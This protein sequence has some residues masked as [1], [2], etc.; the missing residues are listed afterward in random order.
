LL[1]LIREEYKSI[2]NDSDLFIEYS[3][4]GDLAGAMGA[5]YKAFD[6]WEEKL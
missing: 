6:F 4:L 2:N 1:N 3:D 5:A